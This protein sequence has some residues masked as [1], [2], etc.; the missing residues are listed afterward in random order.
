[1]SKIMH[2]HILMAKA[3]LFYKFAYLLDIEG[4]SAEPQGS[5]GEK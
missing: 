5:E 2:K 3:H 1:M 4:I